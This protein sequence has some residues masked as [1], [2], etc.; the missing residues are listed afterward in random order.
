MENATKA[1]LIAA[2]VLVVILIISLG[3]GI[4]NVASESAGNVNLTQQEVQAF[5]Q[6]FVQYEGEAKRGTEV[7]AMLKAVLQSNIKNTAEGK[8][9][10]VVT[11]PDFLPNGTETSLGTTADPS[12]LYDITI[13]YDGTTGL[14]DTI[15][16]A[17]HN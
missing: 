4:F 17:A 13:N 10:Y 6:Q 8:T 16:V 14:V 9:G 7:N 5:N 2:A 11:V 3:V 15:G 12:L 1:L